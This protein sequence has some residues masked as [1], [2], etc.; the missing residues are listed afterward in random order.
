MKCSY[1]P[2]HLSEKL[3]PRLRN[4]VTVLPEV[5]M[6]LV[7]SIVL[8]GKH[9]NGT[10]AIAPTIQLFWCAMLSIT[11]VG[12]SSKVLKNA[13]VNFYTNILLH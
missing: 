6:L 7:G 4:N 8:K 3:L 2:L 13:R 10:R 5:L 9:E 11:A 1:F 12:L